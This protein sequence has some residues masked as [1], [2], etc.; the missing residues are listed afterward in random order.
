M[1]VIFAVYA[2]VLLFSL[3]T[4]GSSSDHLGRRPVSSFAFLVLAAAAVAFELAASP[5][6]LIG[7]RALQGIA[8]AFLLS[9]LA[10]AIVDLEP[11]DKPG[12]AAICNATI[13][14]VGLAVG[15]LASGIIMEHA[16][17]PKAVV[18]IAIAAISVAFSAAIWLLPETSPRHNGL[19]EVLMPRIG[20]PAPARVAFWQSAPAIV[21]GWA[22]AGLYLSLG[23]PIITIVFNANNFLMKSLVVTVL[24]GMGALACFLARNYTP[25][26][27]MLYGTS[28][29]ALGT[30]LTL[31]GVVFAS[32][33][34]YFLA[35]AFAGTGFGTCF[36]ASLKSIVPLTP[37]DERGELFASIFTL[38]YV[39]FGVPAVLAGFMIPYAGFQVTV[40]GYGIIIT[41]LAAIAGLLRKLATE[42]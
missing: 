13:P 29:L 21:A 3:L 20:V 14:M 24:A 41:V 16:A 15:A 23:S 19:L 5:A 25:R 31:I 36:Y 27:I 40:L 28:A 12:L 37:Q 1:T 11:P 26:E 22:T 4:A 33:S 42:N 9:T 34:L 32:L 10:A 35:L 17:H 8:C 30:L 39:A 38:S 2:I 6:G 18:F 7:A